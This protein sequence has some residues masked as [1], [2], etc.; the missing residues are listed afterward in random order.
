[1]KLLSLGDLA[2]S[3]RMAEKRTRPVGGETVESYQVARITILWDRDALVL[4]EV[5][6]PVSVL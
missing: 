2:T 4:D 3:L 5:G 1:M 6:E